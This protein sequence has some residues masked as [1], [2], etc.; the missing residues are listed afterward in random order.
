MA[1]AATRAAAS[2]KAGEV[3]AATRTGVLNGGARATGASVSQS[4]ALNRAAESATSAQNKH[5]FITS[6]PQLVRVAKHA[7]WLAA[8]DRSQLL[9]YRKLD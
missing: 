5:G 9:M 4:G 7:T 8:P 6:V 2:R 3:I 1:R